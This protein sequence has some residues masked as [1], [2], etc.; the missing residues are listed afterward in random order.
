VKFAVEI[1]PQFLEVEELAQVR[2]N[3][4]ERLSQAPLK[5]L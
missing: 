4:S 3:K 5:F 2:E 1:E